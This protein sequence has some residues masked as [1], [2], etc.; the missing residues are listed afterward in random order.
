MRATI[1]CESSLTTHQTQRSSGINVQSAD[2]LHGPCGLLKAPPAVQAAVIFTLACLC[3][4]TT[5]YAQGGWGKPATT[6]PSPTTSAP[7]WP[8][9]KP[10]STQPAPPAP[11]AAT[12]PAAKPQPIASHPPQT[13]QL[14][15]HTPAP[16]PAKSL[17]DYFT[18]DLLLY[19]GIALLCL[20]A[21]IWLVQKVRNAVNPSKIKN[22]APTP[23]GFSV[24]D[25]EKLKD[26]GLLTPAEYERAIARANAAAAASA[27]SPTPASNAAAAPEKPKPR[28]DEPPTA[29]GLFSPSSDPKTPPAGSSPNPRN[30]ELW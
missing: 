18:L 21:V 4:S 9:A 25:I 2:R 24:Q 1:G 30:G 29:P 14:V 28:P 16:P 11:A 26:Q 3:A 5:A 23:A 10:A 19:L 20:A 8:A 7:A 17:S 12:Q 22:A 13:L 27:A 6:Q 15:P